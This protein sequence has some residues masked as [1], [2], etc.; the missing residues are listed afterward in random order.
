MGIKEIEETYSPSRRATK[1][2]TKIDENTK[3]MR[4]IIIKESQA[5]SSLDFLNQR[6]FKTVVKSDNGYLNIA[7]QYF[8]NLKQ[9]NNNIS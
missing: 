3:W 7:I 4:K 5:K 2:L 8:S 1:G 9:N 6:A